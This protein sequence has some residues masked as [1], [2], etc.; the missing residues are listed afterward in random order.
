ML[1]EPSSRPPEQHY[2]AYNALLASPYSKLAKM[3]TPGSET[4]PPL[5]EDGAYFI[6]ACPKAAEFV[7]NCLRRRVV[8]STFNPPMLP[9]G[10]DFEDLIVAAN[11]FMLLHSRRARNYEVR[12]SNIETDQI[13]FKYK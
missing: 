7:L 11:K 10:I 12:N 6:D 5:T 9:A 3:F 8:G 4:S 13:I 1:E 2:N